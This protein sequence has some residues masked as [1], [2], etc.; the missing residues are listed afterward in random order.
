MTHENRSPITSLQGWKSSLLAVTAT[1]GLMAAS[2]QAA[3]AAAV[4]PCECG[5]M[6]VVFV[7]DV[8]GSMGSS[9]NAFK[10]AFPSIVSQISTSSSG[11]VSGAW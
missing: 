9:L 7:V 6:D 8:T 2:A 3:P 11:G 10:S 4:N 1:L 5:P